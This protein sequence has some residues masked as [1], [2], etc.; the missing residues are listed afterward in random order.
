[1]AIGFETDSLKKTVEWGPYKTDYLYSWTENYKNPIIFGFFYSSLRTSSHNMQTYLAEIFTNKTEA[2]E[3][4][5]N[6]SDILINNDENL[7]FYTKQWNITSNFL[8]N[9]GKTIH[10]KLIRDDDLAVT[11]NIKSLK[12]KNNVSIHID[13]E[14]K[15]LK[16]EYFSIFFFLY[17]SKTPL[18]YTFLKNNDII[19]NDYFRFTMSSPQCQKEFIGFLPYSLEIEPDFSNQ[20]DD[21]LL[22]ILDNKP[23]L[24]SQEMNENKNHNLMFLQGIVHNNLKCQMNIL[25]SDAPI[26]A[27]RDLNHQFFLQEFQKNKIRFSEAISS[28]FLSGPQNIYENFSQKFIGLFSDFLGSLGHFSGNIPFIF[29]LK[30]SPL[31]RMKRNYSFLSY[32]PYSLFSQGFGLFLTCKYDL[33]LCSSLLKNLLDQ[34][35]FAGWLPIHLNFPAFSSFRKEKETLTAPPTFFMAIEYLLKSLLEIPSSQIKEFLQNFMKFEIYPKLQ[36]VLKYYLYSFRRLP[37]KFENFNTPY[38]HWNEGIIGDYPRIFENDNTAEHLDLICWISD[39]TIILMQ[40]SNHLGYHA[41]REEY[42]SLLRQF[43][44]FEFP[45]K[46]IN[47]NNYNE[48]KVLRDI[49][50]L[51]YFKSKPFD[52]IHSGRIGFSNLMPLVKGLIDGNDKLC[53]SILELMIDEKALGSE[54]GVKIIDD[55]T[56][57]IVN[58][59]SLECNWLILRGLKMFYKGFEKAQKAYKFIR[60]KL[61]GNIMKHFEKNRKVFDKYRADNGDPIGEAS[62]IAAALVIL[63][64]NEDFY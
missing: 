48:P 35:N 49:L 53:D 19:I 50:S 64:I 36:L 24:P 52:K 43:L 46:Y 30:D 11:F 31:F 17:S 61:L 37:G 4:L 47:L 5:R 2:I 56:K 22:N 15:A 32:E 55:E 60:L 63:I 58:F 18:N 14:G 20:I 41:D 13:L 7:R 40:L 9:D 25:T 28:S 12:K 34:I 54:F 3:I 21:V 6:S 62:K 51:K 26:L 42:S 38:F 45:Q 57:K 29:S 8:I 16:K 59:V 27:S 39:M 23:L 33:M 10:E 44:M 1:M